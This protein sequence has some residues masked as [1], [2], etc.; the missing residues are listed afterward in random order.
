MRKIKILSITI[1]LI[2]TFGI[3]NTV[4]GAIAIK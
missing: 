3:I 1:L 2:I 4:N